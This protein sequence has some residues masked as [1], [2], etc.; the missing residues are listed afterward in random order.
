MLLP[1]LSA[2]STRNKKGVV[3]LTPNTALRPKK[4]HTILQIHTEFILPFPEPLDGPHLRLLSFSLEPQKLDFAALGSQQPVCHV[5]L[6]ADTRWP[7]P[8]TFPK[9]P[10]QLWPT[11]E[12]GGFLQEI[13]GE[14][15]QDVQA[16]QMGRSLAKLLS[17]RES[18]LETM[19]Q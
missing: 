10:P 14:I 18:P 1:K 5:K 8:T 15:L 6:T 12:A 11:S 13:L 2:R 9:P 7:S 3:A 19:I 16:E 17:Y 4:P